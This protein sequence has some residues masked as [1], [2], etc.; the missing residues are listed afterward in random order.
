MI[1]ARLRCDWWGTLLSLLWAQIE[2][3]SPLRAESLT[4]ILLHHEVQQP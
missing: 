1:S 4:P 3:G 2:I